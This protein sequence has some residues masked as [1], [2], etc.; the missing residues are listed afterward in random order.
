MLGN[1]LVMALSLV[2]VFVHSRDGYTAVVPTGLILS[3]IVVLILM[4]TGW[5]DWSM[6]YHHRV[7][8]TE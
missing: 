5:M 7:G 3:G 4:F 1:L 6:V 8:V 2:N